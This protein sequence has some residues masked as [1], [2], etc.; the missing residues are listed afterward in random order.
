M[1]PF[2]K[3]LFSLNEKMVDFAKKGEPPNKYSITFTPRNGQKAM[4]RIPAI[5]SRFYDGMRKEFDLQMDKKLVQ[6]KDV[7]KK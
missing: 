6:F 4:V 3:T 1:N 7:V 2:S 5:K